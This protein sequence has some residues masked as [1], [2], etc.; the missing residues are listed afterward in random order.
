MAVK[1]SDLQKKVLACF[2]GKDVII[3]NTEICDYLDTTRA[4]ANVEIS[5]LCDK[6]LL[7]KVR[8]GEHK[9]NLEKVNDL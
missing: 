1:L 7:I 3:K 5:R 2:G 6:G 9:L 8:K 4:V